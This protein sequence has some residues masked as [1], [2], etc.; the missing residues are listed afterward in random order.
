MAAMLHLHLLSLLLSSSSSLSS[1]SAVGGA[2]VPS[3]QWR[4]A[5]AVL[6]P[7]TAC[8]GTLITPDIVL[9]AGHCIDPAPVYVVVDTVDYVKP[10][11]EPIRVKSALAYPGWEDAYDV[12]ILVL[13]RPST[14]TP[15]AVAAD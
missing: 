5:V 11:G 8:T 13:D 15:R 6:S 14:I 2:P 9:T 7:T 12:G 10:G 3:G 4:D 1:S